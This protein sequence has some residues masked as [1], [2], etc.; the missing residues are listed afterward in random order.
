MEGRWREDITN[1]IERRT[2]REEEDGDICRGC[3]RRLDHRDAFR[4]SVRERRG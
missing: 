4:Y 2:R 1:D 3:S